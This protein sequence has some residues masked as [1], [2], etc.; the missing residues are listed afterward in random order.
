MVM[1][2]SNLNRSNLAQRQ[3]RLQHEYILS[4]ET[5]LIHLFFIN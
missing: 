3:I 2:I 4:V 1:L 5:L